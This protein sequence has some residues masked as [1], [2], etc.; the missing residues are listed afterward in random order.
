MIQESID[1]GNVKDSMIG[2]M[3]KNSSSNLITFERH[4]IIS[5]PNSARSKSGLKHGHGFDSNDGRESPTSDTESVCSTIS[6]TLRPDHSNR[7]DAI[8]LRTLYK[9]EKPKLSY[10]A[11]FTRLPE[12]TADL[13][14]S[15]YLTR[16]IR[17]VWKQFQTIEYHNETATACG[18][19]QQ[20]RETIA[21]FRSSLKLMDRTSTEV[22]L[23]L[24]IGKEFCNGF[25][26]S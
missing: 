7:D 17:R 10:S 18:D 24:F 4:P 5:R 8:D 9:L 26:S 14:I 1:V 12:V 6:L 22:I 21:S 23:Q 13:P 19:V 11:W 15:E 20:R 25:M 2:T 16:Y 3:K